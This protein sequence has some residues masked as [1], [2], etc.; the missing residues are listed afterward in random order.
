MAKMRKVKSTGK[1]TFTRSMYPGVAFC[2]R[3]FC[4][5]NQTECPFPLADFNPTQV[6][7]E[8]VPY[9]ASDL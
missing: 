9:H 4:H 1:A 7:L 5:H 6:T 3:C 8:E 2:E